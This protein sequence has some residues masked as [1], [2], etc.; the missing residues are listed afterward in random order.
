MKTQKTFHMVDPRTAG[1]KKGQ[2][3]L[4]EDRAVGSQHQHNN[5]CRLWVFYTD[6]Q[7]DLGVLG[8]GCGRKSTFSTDGG[9]A[10]C[11]L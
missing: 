3:T 9:S 6:S 7:S 1:E 2:V 4:G 8:R 10:G 11:D 5:D